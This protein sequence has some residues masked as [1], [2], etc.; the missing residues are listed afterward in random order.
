VLEIS[1]HR[2]AVRLR[3]RGRVPAANTSR[4]A[5]LLTTKFVPESEGQASRK[6]AS[7]RRS[8]PAP[9]L[10]LSP[11]P[12]ESAVPH[13]GERCVGPSSGVDVPLLVRTRR[14][15]LTSAGD[16][17]RLPAL[18]RGWSRHEG[19][20]VAISRGRLVGGMTEGLM[21]EAARSEVAQTPGAAEAGRYDAFLSYAREDSAFA[22]E[23]LRVSL[24][25]RSLR[26]WVDVE[27]IQGGAVWE[28]RIRRGIEACKAFIFVISPDSVASEACL[29]ELALAVAANKLIIPLKHRGEVADDDLPRALSEH[30]WIFLSTLDDD[31]GMA[32]LVEALEEDL[33]W[34]DQHT[35]LA[36]RAREWL[37]NDRDRSYLLRGSDLR[38]AESWLGRQEGHRQ[39]PTA[40]H[41]EYIARSR[42]AAGR[43]LRALLGGLGV[44]LAVAIAAAVVAIGQRDEATHQR[45]RAT[46]Q[47]TIAESRQLAAVASSLGSTNLAL[48]LPLAVA[49]YRTDANDQTETALFGADLASPKLWRFL[50]FPAT[51]SQLAGSA[52]GRY[53][54]A[55][56]D[57][58]RVMRWRLGQP[59]PRTVIRLHTGAAT[60]LAVDA[61]GN[62][63]VAANGSTEELWR[64]GRTR[65][66]P[67][68]AEHPVAA[69][70]SPSGNTVAVAYERKPYLYT[71]HAVAV[72]SGT[73]GQRL[74]VARYGARFVHP[75]A[76][77]LRGKRLYLLDGGTGHWAILSVPSLSELAVS[78]AYYVGAHNY[79]FGYSANGKLFAFNIGGSPMFVYTTTRPNEPAA[80]IFQAQAPVNRPSALTLSTRHELAASESGIIYLAP[81][82]R[83]GE[84]A[85]S[86]TT[87]TGVD[88]VNTGTLQFVD[89]N[90]LL[91][92]SGRSV[93]VWRLD[94]IDRLA[95]R[96]SSRIAT[97]PCDECRGATVTVAPDGRR[98]ALVDDA[99]DG[100]IQSIV[101]TGSTK[102]VP[103]GHDAIGPAVWDPTTHR[104]VLVLGRAE[105][106][107]IP[108]DPVG[109][110]RTLPVVDATS[111]GAVV[112]SG[113]LAGGRFGI[114]NGHGDTFVITATGQIVSETH[115][116]K[117]LAG[118]AELQPVEGD[119][120]VDG[121]RS[122]A[123][124]LDQSSELGGPFQSV[125]VKS[126]GARN[127]MV[128]IGGGGYTAVA[129]ADNRLLLQRES[130]Q[131]DVYDY[132]GR[133]RLLTLQGDS[134]DTLAPVGSATGDLVAR[135]R[136]DASV[137]LQ[138]VRTGATIATLPAPSSNPAG[139]FLGLGFSPSG[140]TLVEAV[141]DPPE[142]PYL[143]TRDVSLSSLAAVACRSASDE[144][145]DAAWRAYIGGLAPHR[146]PCDQ[147]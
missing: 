75:S 71:A 17:S 127:R 13:C 2:P 12:R 99:G 108:F 129:Y 59:A 136:T 109:I 46:R 142:K 140:N 72:F 23:G 29:K 43:R 133:R 138:N 35:R 66:L 44:V 41:S 69:T 6:N 28:E 22:V 83:T 81:L 122:V 119:A 126:L 65:S 94:Q 125:L 118:T 110:P 20:T 24:N 120:A 39:A 19:Q 7:L 102:A 105:L 80:G 115:G 79:G 15:V 25:D 68:P 51:I 4:W 97:D 26:I 137:L 88:A 93:A 87:L 124:M 144:L 67:G 21:K 55:A 130:G 34:R 139:L 33:G 78:T 8:A 50:A 117:D 114:V 100:V 111:T 61:A 112:A 58:G 77:V 131:I 60:S 3:E 73:T 113:A 49:G 57:D 147:P 53:V 106:A 143:L 146:L 31:T 9:H 98:V 11:P 74:T 16:R 116:P 36:G 86:P 95:T 128:R 1:S 141:E 132:S 38:A 52:D 48:A 42:Q 89:P 45:D 91:S 107:G 135:Q 101:G 70:V 123:A 121:A 32:K 92:A 96:G 64:D 103:N 27:D 5:R 14:A 145:D 84:G 56:L 54:V 18:V 63:V 85:L 30:E 104:L 47:A 10:S 40:E 76:L 37:D 90:E 62:V 82:T 134:S